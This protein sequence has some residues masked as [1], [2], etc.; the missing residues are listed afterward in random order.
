MEQKQQLKETKPE[1][2]KVVYGK[3]VVLGS[4]VKT[5]K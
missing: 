4:K 5:G 1:R 3:N 2:S